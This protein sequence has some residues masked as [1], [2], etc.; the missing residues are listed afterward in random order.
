LNIALEASQNRLDASL[1]RAASDAS[2][3]AEHIRARARAEM[4]AAGLAAV[5][6]LFTFCTW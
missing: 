3:Q 1:N 6:A 2:R 5:L 4:L